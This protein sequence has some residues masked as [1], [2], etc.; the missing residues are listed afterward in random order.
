MPMNDLVALACRITS[1]VFS[2]EMV[3]EIRLADGTVHQG[4]ASRR[5]FFTTAGKPMAAHEPIGDQEVEGLVL[6][7]VLQK[8]GDR[9]LVSIPDGEVVTVEEDLIS[10][11]V[12][13]PGRVFV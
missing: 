8:H 3:F 5:Y 9:V 6:A 10:R 2:S 7:Q 12:E 1:G 11:C 13:D 4:V